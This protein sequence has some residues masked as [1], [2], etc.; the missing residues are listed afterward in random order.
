MGVTE[1]VRLKHTACRKLVPG[2]RVIRFLKLSFRQVIVVA[3]G[4]WEGGW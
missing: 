1:H 3:D 2:A 4:E